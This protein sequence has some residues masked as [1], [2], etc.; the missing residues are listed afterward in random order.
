MGPLNI[1]AGLVSLLLLL[2]SVCG[3]ESMLHVV[4]VTLIGS[5]ALLRHSTYIR[6][7]K[8]FWSLD[9]GAAF[10]FYHKTSD[11]FVEGKVALCSW[12]FFECVVV[13]R[14]HLNEIWLH[15][16]ICSFKGVFSLGLFRSAKLNSG[17]K[18]N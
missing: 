4:L 8:V 6:N 9:N 10:S 13:L 15:A 5:L 3:G 11:Y 7:L 12:C 16:S 17:Y 18:F 14:R 1:S 2:K